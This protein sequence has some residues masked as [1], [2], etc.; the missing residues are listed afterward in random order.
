MDRGNAE[1]NDS[2]CKTSSDLPENFLDFKLSPEEEAAF[3][4]MVRREKANKESKFCL[5]LCKGYPDCECGQ[6][7]RSVYEKYGIKG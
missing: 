2:L 7:N 6:F 1:T 5:P 3:D 4:G